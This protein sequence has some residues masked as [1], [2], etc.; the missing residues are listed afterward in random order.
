MAVRQSRGTHRQTNGEKKKER[1]RERK[2]EKE[3]ENEKK[4]LVYTASAIPPQWRS[5]RAC[6]CTP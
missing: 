3:R 5:T 4:K 1:E 6:A 2:K